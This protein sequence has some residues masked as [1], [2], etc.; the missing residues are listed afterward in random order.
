MNDRLLDSVVPSA[1]MREFL[2]NTELDTVSL[3]Q[4]IAGSPAPLRVKAEFAEGEEKL[5]YLEAI[6]TLK[7]EK[8]SD[9][10]GKRRFELYILNSYSDFRHIG[11]F[12]R[13][14]LIEQY[15]MD[16]LESA[17]D[18]F[19]T[20]CPFYFIAVLC[21]ENAEKQWIPRGAYIIL[22]GEP[23][24]YVEAKTK[25]VFGSLGTV[26]DILCSPR[27]ETELP[28]PYRVG[29]ILTLD[30]LPFAPPVYALMIKDGTK[31]EILYRYIGAHDSEFAWTIDPLLSG[32]YLT[33]EDYWEGTVPY[34]SP[35]YRLKKFDGELPEEDKPLLRA[36]EY[37]GRDSERGELIRE[38]LYSAARED[39]SR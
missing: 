37:I 19:G 11:F 15:I 18:W 35:L 16:D 33:E 4:L 17:S 7:L 14:S 8:D 2:K 21:N 5:R 29:D 32:P 39:E 10:Y 38:Y 34:L 30:C 12:A 28:V 3:S 31:P 22:D 9:E 26:A 36:K 6:K 13:Y 27:P 23:V 1:E 24:W 25:S 20:D